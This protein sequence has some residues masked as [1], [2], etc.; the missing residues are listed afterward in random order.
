[1]N[2]IMIQLDKL[3]AESADAL[4]RF[5]DDEEMYTKY[6]REFPDEPTMTRLTAAVENADYEE[7]E[8]AVHALKG[9][10]NNLGFLPLADAAIDMLEELR[11]D[12]IE[13][14]LDAYKDVVEEYQKFTDVI[15]EWRSAL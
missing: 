3:G 6:I 8:K 7:A 5:M 14:A 1:M 2:E 10:V 9:I 4:A 15:R 11:D 12:N 13:D